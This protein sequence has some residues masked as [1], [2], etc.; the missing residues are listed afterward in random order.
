MTEKRSKS[1][2]IRIIIGIIQILFSVVSML[3]LVSMTM[4]NGSLLFVIL[5]ILGGIYQLNA[6]FIIHIVLEILLFISIPVT[7]FNSISGVLSLVGTKKPFQIFCS[8]VGTTSFLPVIAVFYLWDQY[9]FFNQSLNL[10]YYG[11]IGLAI[12]SLLLL[13][14][15]IIPMRGY[16]LIRP[17]K[18]A[19]RHEVKKLKKNRPRTA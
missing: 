11:I 5:F 15:I 19:I 13:M 17:V 6:Y 18:M 1:F 7:F 3:Y 14:T 16:R 12:S 4:M 10:H 9:Q 2:Y 8:V